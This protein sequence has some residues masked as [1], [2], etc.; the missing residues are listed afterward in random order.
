MNEGI[1]EEAAASS[2]LAL[3]GEVS[4]NQN[5]N[6]NFLPFTNFRSLSSSNLSNVGSPDL[7]TIDQ[8]NSTKGTSDEEDI[9]LIG[10]HDKNCINHGRHCCHSK[11]CDCRA[12]LI[13]ANSCEPDTHYHTC[14][15]CFIRIFGNELPKLIGTSPFKVVFGSNHELVIQSLCTNKTNITLPEWMRSDAEYEAKRARRAIVPSNSDA[16]YVTFP[17]YSSS[18]VSIYK[19][20]HQL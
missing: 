10:G 3:S 2:L 17:L 8:F 5:E 15:D 9:I 16:N 20:Y 7:Y 11:D 18:T 12:L 4:N 19:L 14:Y 6:N 1:Q 13:L